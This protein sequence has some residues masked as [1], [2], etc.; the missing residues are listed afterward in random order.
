MDD[1]FE[2]RHNLIKQIE[3]CHKNSFYSSKS[4]PKLVAV[5]KQQPDYKI[6]DALKAT[7]FALSYLIPLSISA[8]NLSA[9]RLTP[10]IALE[11]IIPANGIINLGLYQ[12]S[13]CNSN[14][15]TINKF[16]PPPSA[17]EIIAYFNKLILFS[18]RIRNAIQLP[19]ITIDIK[20]HKTINELLDLKM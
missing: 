6:K 14:C 4:L 12:G 2:N 10:F 19:I 15:V 13:N 7:L 1:I 3:K 8:C 20:I 9:A 17:I 16:M 11:K 18:F 5:S